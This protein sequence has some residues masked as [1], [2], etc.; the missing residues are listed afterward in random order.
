MFARRIWTFTSGILVAAALGAVLARCSRDGLSNMEYVP[1]QSA[2]TT[3]VPAT[4]ATDG[5][6]VIGQDAAVP[7]RVPS[8][9]RLEA[10]EDLTNGDG[11]LVWLPPEDAGSSPVTSYR[12]SYLEPGSQTWKDLPEVSADGS[13]TYSQMM[14]VATNGTYSFRI[15][16]I[17]AAGESE[18]GF[19]NETNFTFK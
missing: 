12:V 1:P 16:A 2:T 18:P 3:A 17:N 13:S 14:H 11:R 4:I 9:P 5:V 6:P 15:V 8:E 19:E 10:V 7:A